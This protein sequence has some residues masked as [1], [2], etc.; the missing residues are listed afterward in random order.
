MPTLNT[1]ARNAAATAV[2]GTY[3][4][5]T[6]VIYEGLTVLATHTLTGFGAAA[7]GVVTANA[8]SNVTVA[9]SGTANSAKLIAG[10]NEVT[11]TVG[12]SAAEVVM[13]TLSL[14]IGGTS[15]INSL[16]ITMPAS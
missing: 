15:Q 12:T 8:I 2:A 11:L 3:A 16:T 7:S 6:L 9:A 13:S 10:A 5:G 4:S 14:V 1:A